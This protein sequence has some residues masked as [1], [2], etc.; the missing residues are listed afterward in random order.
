[1]HQTIRLSDYVT[2]SLCHYLSVYLSIPPSMYVKL[3]LNIVFSCWRCR[4]NF[5]WSFS[6][7]IYTGTMSHAK[8]VYVALPLSSLVS[9]SSWY[10]LENIMASLMYNKL[11]K[12][13]GISYA[14]RAPELSLII[15]SLKTIWNDKL[16]S[17]I[18][19]C[20][21]QRKVVPI[22]PAMSWGLQN[23]FTL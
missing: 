3:F 2:M 22:D 11:R 1:M 14:S 16:S 6:L 20:G 9:I 4:L 10:N 23:Y 7:E 13:K 5:K 17:I 18:P 12:H 15:V 19:W 8:H 21:E